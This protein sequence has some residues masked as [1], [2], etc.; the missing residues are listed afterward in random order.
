MNIPKMIKTYTTTLD[1]QYKERTSN[2]LP[3]EIRDALLIKLTT[4][5]CSTKYHGCEPGGLVFHLLNVYNLAIGLYMQLKIKET[6]LKLSSL[7]LLALVHDLGK[8]GNL[9]DDFYLPNTG[10]NADKEPFKVNLNLVSISHEIRTL[11]W[12]RLLGINE[13]SEEELQAICYHAGP[14]M[15][16]YLTAVRKE[17]LLLVLLHTADNLS[18]KVLEV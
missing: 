17:S 18:T 11:Y 13:L 3:C 14:Y 1:T 15:D 16:G 5:P 4:C 2:D 9:E 10:S 8:I 7:K 6:Q 12:L